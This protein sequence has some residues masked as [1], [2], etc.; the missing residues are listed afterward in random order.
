MPRVKS[1]RKVSGDSPVT[2]IVLQG[3][4]GQIY[5]LGDLNATIRELNAAT[6]RVVEF[7]GIFAGED[8]PTVGPLGIPPDKV[9]AVIGE[10]T[11]QEAHESINDNEIVVASPGEEFPI[12]VQ[13][14]KPR[15]Q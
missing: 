9:T 11:A 4:M 1:L 13:Q 12:P 8:E 14:K 2:I 7:E 3:L 5:L 6:L 10:C 15:L